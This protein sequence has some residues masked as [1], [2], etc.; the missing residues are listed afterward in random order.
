[1]KMHR[2]AKNEHGSR[3]SSCVVPAVA[4][5]ITLSIMGHISLPMVISDASWSAAV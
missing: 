4:F 2:G 5:T 3:P 1:M